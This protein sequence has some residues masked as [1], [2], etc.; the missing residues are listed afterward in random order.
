[1]INETT[2]QKMTIGLKRSILGRSTRSNRLTMAFIREKRI[3]GNL[4]GSVI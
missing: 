2:M 3:E 1:M 4:P